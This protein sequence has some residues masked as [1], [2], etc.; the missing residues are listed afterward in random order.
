[1]YGELGTGGFNASGSSVPVQVA[2]VG[3]SGTLSSVTSLDLTYHSNGSNYGGSVYAVLGTGELVSWGYGVSGVL[4]TDL[5]STLGYGLP[6]NGY[7][8]MPVASPAG[9]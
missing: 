4:G 5:L 9:A 2:G 3:G 7:S 6:W 1:L 8:P